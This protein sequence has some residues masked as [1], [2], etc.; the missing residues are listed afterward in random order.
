[1]DYLGVSCIDFIMHPNIEYKINVLTN[2]MGRVI[3]VS[4]REVQ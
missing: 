4:I 3:T 1:M 2:R